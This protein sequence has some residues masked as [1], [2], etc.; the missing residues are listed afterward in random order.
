MSYSSQEPGGEK[1]A[2]THRRAR[3]GLSSCSK[4]MGRLRLHA[5]P[6][7]IDSR[8]SPSTGYLF[9]ALETVMIDTM[10]ELGP[11]LHLRRPATMG[12]LARVLAQKARILLLSLPAASLDLRR[13]LA[14]LATLRSEAAGGEASR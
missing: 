1:R 4:K 11:R 9:T 14:S 3:R 6:V 12:L 2:S 8:L 10:R 5:S 13:H 7:R